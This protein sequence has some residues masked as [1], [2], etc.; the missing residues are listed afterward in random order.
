LLSTRWWW[1]TWSRAAGEEKYAPDLLLGGASA[2]PGM[3]FVLARRNRAAVESLYVRANAMPTVADVRTL[4]TG[5]GPV[6]IVL[7]A[8]GVKPRDRTLANGV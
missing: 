8:A 3:L 2:E 4:Q 5:R 7:R 1:R 6:L